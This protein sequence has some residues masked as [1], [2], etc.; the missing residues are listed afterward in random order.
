MV[1]D[2]RK[3]RPGNIGF[4]ASRYLVI[5]LL[6]L[7]FIA[8]PENDSNE[9][10]NYDP[11]NV[12]RIDDHIEAQPELA[13]DSEGNVHI[14][15]FGGPEYNEPLDVYYVW[16]NEN[17]IW[18]KPINISNSVNDSRVP[19]IALD[20]REN[21]HVIWEE[22]GE[23]N[24]RTK[25]TMKKINEDWDE[26]VYITSDYNGLPQIAVDGN[27]HVHIVGFG[28]RLQYRK[29]VGDIWMT[30]EVIDSIGI[31]N[32][33]LKV[34]DS[35]NIFVVG[36]G[37]NPNRIELVTRF[38]AT[39]Q[40]KREFISDSNY[41]PWAAAVAVGNNGKIYVAWTLADKDQINYRIKNTE[42]VWSEV[43]SIPNMIGDPLRSHLAVDDT[44][45]HVV[46]NAHTEE[47]DYDIYYQ[48]KSHN[49]DWSDKKQISLTT[50][51]SLGQAIFLNGEVLFVAWHE[52]FIKN[53]NSDIYYETIPLMY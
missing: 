29:K 14:V 30:E 47:W 21:I 36:E 3:E 50:F 25:Y 26:P 42:G 11:R 48:M 20:S 9:D 43:D 32:H 7:S 27:D 8:C 37:G 34:S 13:V 22:D 28:F 24:G 33:T 44:G 52:I 35:G 46:W 12:T 40:W 45:L 17:D 2:N 23:G 10:G 53:I 19:Q 16:K 39:G 41:R 6:F 18:S 4:Q 49:G 38:A 1:Q 31:I 51:P 15:Y 5:L